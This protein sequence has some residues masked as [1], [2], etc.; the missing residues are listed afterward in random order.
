MINPDIEISRLRNYLDQR[1]I[2]LD[3]ID[4]ICDEAS[5]EINDIILEVVDNAVSECI[6][7]AADIGCHDFIEEMDII[8]AG[9]SYRIHT[10]SGKTDYTEPEFPMK[11]SLLKNA[12]VSKDGKRY[13]VIP[14]G[15]SNP[16][17][18][19]SATRPAMT[20]SFQAQRERQSLVDSARA[21][22]KEDAD[23]GSSAWATSMTD[24]YRSRLA[25]GVEQRKQFYSARRDA[26][27]KDITQSKPEFR[28][29]SED[30]PDDSWV[31]PRKELDMTAF[32]MEMNSRI[33]DNI[34]H[35]V[36]KVVNTYMDSFR[37]I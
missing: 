31:R 32:L 37:S 12:K 27:K 1:G 25:A 6:D 11:D 13:K 14:I 3:F 22:L 15:A 24:Q 9:G 35:N 23:S 26:I 30:S 5:A 36:S 16:S 2:D 19:K 21:A 10:I 18:D 29:V 33:E 17:S 28:V 34:E 20:S 7:H 4:S 8:Q